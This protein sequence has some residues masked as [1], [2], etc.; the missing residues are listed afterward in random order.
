MAGPRHSGG[1][2]GGRAAL[3]GA[4]APNAAGAPPRFRALRVAAEPPARWS[5]RRHSPSYIFFSC[6]ALIWAGVKVST[7][8]ALALSRTEAGTLLS[9]SVSFAAITM[10]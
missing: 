4:A 9:A 8:I 6:I 7:F 1:G 2:L 3:S 5:A 10:R